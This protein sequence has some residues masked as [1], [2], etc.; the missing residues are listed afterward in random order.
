MDGEDM[1]YLETLYD[2]AGGRTTEEVWSGLIAERVS[3]TEQEDLTVGHQIR[4]RLREA[5][6][7]L[8]NPPFGSRVILT[9]ASKDELEK[10][11]TPR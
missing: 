3:I 11:R 2:L 4:Y 10:R 9:E 5:G 6:L 1:R 8:L 7:V